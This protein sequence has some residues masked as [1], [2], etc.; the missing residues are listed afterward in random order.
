MNLLNDPDQTVRK[1]AAASLGSLKAEEAIEPLVRM[2][3][4]SNAAERDAA[5]SALWA[6][7]SA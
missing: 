4:A 7:A 3:S 1:R 6:I 5:L 2:T